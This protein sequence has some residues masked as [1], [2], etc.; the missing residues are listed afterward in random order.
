MESEGDALG[1]QTESEGISPA[2]KIKPAA[3]RDAAKLIS[4]A[5]AQAS[6]TPAGGESGGA[7]PVGVLNQ[8]PDLANF[9]ERLTGLE[10][11]LRERTTLILDQHTSPLDLL[12][13]PA[14]P[15]PNPPFGGSATPK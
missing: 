2:E 14:G 12:N 5:E 10:L 8:E 6:R 4:D 3:I 13:R 11:Y 1:S 7:K 15:S 9:V